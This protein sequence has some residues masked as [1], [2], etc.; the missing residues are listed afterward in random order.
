MAYLIHLATSNNVP[1][2]QAD[3]L[4]YETKNKKNYQDPT[5]RFPAFKY[6]KAPTVSETIPPP[7]PETQDIHVH[8]WVKKTTK[9]NQKQDYSDSSESEDEFITE[10]DTVYTEKVERINTVNKRIKDQMSTPEVNIED[11]IKIAQTPV[12]ITPLM[13]ED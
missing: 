3:W 9:L 8:E 7:Q 4:A 11:A 2:Y 12:S 13:N 5:S 10:G 6:T 1:I